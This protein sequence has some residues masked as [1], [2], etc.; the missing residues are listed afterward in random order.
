MRGKAIA[1]PLAA[2]PAEMRQEVRPCVSCLAVSLAGRNRRVSTMG[3]YHRRANRRAEGATRRSSEP[4][5]FNEA[6][7]RAHRTRRA[8]A[9]WR[10]PIR[11]AARSSRAGSM[12][13]PRQVDQESSRSF[14]IRRADP[15]HPRFAWACCAY[16]ALPRNAKSPPVPQSAAVGFGL[17]R[18][19]FQSAALGRAQPPRSRPLV[20]LVLLVPS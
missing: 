19:G 10:R 15:P 7:C 17:P 2:A 18:S 5:S 9:S 8:L 3:V 4:P 20:L 1:S 14:L 12:T 16:S 11:R 6:K 13:P